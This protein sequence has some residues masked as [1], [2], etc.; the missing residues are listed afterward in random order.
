MVK[1]AVDGDVALVSFELPSVVAATSVSVCGEFNDWSPDAQ[2]LARLEDGRFRAVVPLAG[3]RRWRFRYL[4]DGQRWENDWAADDYVPN[5]YGSHDSVVDLT[6]VL[7]SP[8]IEARQPTGPDR[9]DDQA[10]ERQDTEPP[11]GVRAPVR[12]RRRKAPGTEGP[13][14]TAAH[15]SAPASTSTVAEPVSRSRTK[16]DQAGAPR[17]V[18]GTSSRRRRKPV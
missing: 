4:L 7:P 17:T 16:A 12:G 6:G 8:T 18:P 10:S 14:T 5:G 1:S 3:G 9:V 2:P 11:A 13:Q 15:G